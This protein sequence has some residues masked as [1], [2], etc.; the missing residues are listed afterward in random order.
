MSLCLPFSGFP[1]VLFDSLLSLAAAIEG[2]RERE[3]ERDRAEMGGADA[4][5]NRNLG[6]ARYCL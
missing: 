3:G 5:L 1:F 2:G 6:R 4:P